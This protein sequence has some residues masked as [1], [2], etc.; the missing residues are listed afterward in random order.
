MT[1]QAAIVERPYSQ[2]FW[3]VRAEGGT[4]LGNFRL[5]Q[6]V[7]IGHLDE[8]GIPSDSER[9]YQVDPIALR[10][11]VERHFADREFTKSKLT[12]HWSQ[13]SYFLFEMKPGDWV[14]SVD[15]NR[16]LIGRIVG[17]P[18]YNTDPIDYVHDIDTGR[19]TRMTLGLRR[20]VQWGPSIIRGNLPSAVTRT[21]RA[22]QT[23]FN[24][25]DHWQ[26]LYHLVYPAFSFEDRLYLSA[27]VQQQ[28]SI[29]NLSVSKFLTL[30][31]ELE[32]F[33]RGDFPDSMI[34]DAAEVAI[35]DALND[36]YDSGSLTLSTQAEFMSPGDIWSVLE[37]L[38]NFDYYAAFYFGYSALFGSS[39]LG[40]DG[41]LDLH[42]RQRVMD[43][44]AKRWEGRSGK[45][46]R[47]RLKLR[48]PSFDTKSL[49]DESKDEK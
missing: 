47:A 5:G 38:K 28:N 41:L 35:D 39:V 26:T 8:L 44:I 25:D 24:V 1:E 30:M 42:T 27:K 21:L 9:P 16:L 11:R 33:V 6:C 31:S 37:H 34:G 20:A 7:A 29:D 13:I 23:V 18:R 43:F 17:K 36:G 49:E 45:Q 4:Y 32:A 14:V 19:L 12:S 3:V 15:D 48:L 2:R 22:N 10:D 40:W 46:I